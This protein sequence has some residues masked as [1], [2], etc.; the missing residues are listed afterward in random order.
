MANYQTGSKIGADLTQTSSAAQFTLGDHLLSNNDGE[1]VY[2][3]ANGA[4]TAGDCVTITSSGT[5][6]RATPA[7]VAAGYEM[8]FAQFA[9]ADT[10]YGWVGR[11]GNQLTVNCSSTT[12]LNA[13]LY[14]GSSG[15]LSSTAS[16][17]TVAGVSLSYASTSATVQAIPAFVSWPRASLANA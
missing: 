1:W 5:A 11:R 12:A 14:I 17:G 16:S 4:I 8:A 15:K 2:V 3:L 7:N 9:F 13:V 10:E 6:T